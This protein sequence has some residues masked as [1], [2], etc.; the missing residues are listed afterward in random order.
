ARVVSLLLSDVPG[1]D[2]S[3]IASG[4]TVPDPTRCADALEILKRF[5][6]A[7]P[8]GIRALLESGAGETPKPGDPAF[9]RTET[10]MVATPADMLAAA[11]RAAREAGA[12]VE[13]LGDD[14]EGEA[15]E[16]GREHA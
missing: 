7:V 6:V 5:S 1:D 9:A 16:L 2:P 10:I 14:L 13:I 11:A 3:V 15:R 12:T 8:P 4:P